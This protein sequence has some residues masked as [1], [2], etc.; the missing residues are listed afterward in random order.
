MFCV[1]SPTEALAVS[2][3]IVINSFRISGENG[4]ND[5][6]VEILNKSNLEVNLS[7]WKLERKTAG[8]SASYLRTSF[9]EEMKIAGGSKIVIA[10]PSCTCNI[11]L[12]YATS[13]GSTPS[14]LASDNSIILYDQ[15]KTVIDK[16]GYGK[17][18]D[19]ETTAISDSPK[20][21]EILSRR[22]GGQDT[23]NNAADFYL[24]YAP[25]VVEEPPTDEPDS[26]DSSKSKPIVTVGAKIKVSEFMPNPEGS[27]TDGEWIEIYNAGAEANISG[28][29]ITDMVGSPKKYKFP[30][31]TII[32]SK[33]Y[34]AFYS[35]KTPI[36]LNNDDEG[37]QL[38]DPDG[39]VIDAS[40]KSGKGSEGNSFAYDGSNWSWTSQPTPG[41]ANVII[42]P[43]GKESSNKKDQAVL[44][45]VDESKFSPQ[46]TGNVSQTESKN[47]QLLGYTLIVLA[48]L[49]A[50]SYTLYI[51]KEKLR[52]I[53]HK[54]RRGNRSTGSEIW[55]KIKGR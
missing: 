3:T 44:A 40:T 26:P 37:V 55:Q 52:G 17:A 10:H 2:T 29:A 1:I 45:L 38:L 16:V 9:P 15:A 20:D 12:P 11:G 42:K 19:V 48:I 28:Y 13:T 23:D 4:S 53:Y 27:D 21:G 31:G 46:E 49:G 18:T 25:P 8:G 32:K 43:E 41:R 34:L 50:I 39:K 6:Y 54:I 51:N 47:D 5:E 35:S 30:E 22:N 7:G 14:G 33:Q 24:A 36:S